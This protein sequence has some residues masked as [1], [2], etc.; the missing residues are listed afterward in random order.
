MTITYQTPPDAVLW[1]MRAALLGYG[2]Y[3]VGR[4]LFELVKE[5]LDHRRD[6]AA[7]DRDLDAWEAHILSGV[8]EDGP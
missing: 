1:V 4:S 2:L 5:W 8:K 3:W 7:L 6:M